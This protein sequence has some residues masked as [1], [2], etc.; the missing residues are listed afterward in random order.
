MAWANEVLC[1]D[2]D[3]QALES[4]VLTW[5]EAEGNVKKWREEAKK[6][7]THKLRTHF[8]NIELA[9]DAAE[10]LD[11]IDNPVEAF[12]YA[13]SFLSLHLIC[14]DAMTVAGDMWDTKA[15]MYLEK[16]DEEWTKALGLMHIDI[17]ESGTIEI[18]E[19]YYYKTGVVIRR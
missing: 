10:V 4:G 13:A 1:T 8:M 7:I 16:F 9:T 14:N 3:L 12:A 17:D 18:G 11:L 19:K 15:R 5:A 6:Q 2:S